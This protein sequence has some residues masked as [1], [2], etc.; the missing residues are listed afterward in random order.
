M[1]LNWT[2]CGK[3]TT[4]LFGKNCSAH[5]REIKFSGGMQNSVLP[6]HIEVIKIYVCV[7]VCVLKLFKFVIN[8]VKVLKLLKIT[9]STNQ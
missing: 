8:A 6:L 3:K 7:C 2:L 4:K 5:G 1:A 9:V